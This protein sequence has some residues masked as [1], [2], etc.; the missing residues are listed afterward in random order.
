MFSKHKSPIGAGPMLSNRLSLKRIC[1]S[2]NWSV[3]TLSIFSNAIRTQMRVW[4]LRMFW[5]WNIWPSKLTKN[6]IIYIERLTTNNLSLNSMRWFVTFCLAVRQ[7]SQSLR[8]G[9]W[10]VWFSRIWVA[11]LNC[12]IF[13]W[14]PHSS[15]DTVIH[16][17]GYVWQCQWG[18]GGLKQSSIESHLY[19]K[20]VSQR[21]SL[22]EM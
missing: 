5:C 11:I 9:W 17:V 13:G 22:D 1:A 14:D 3:T 16:N 8:F 12:I 20:S 7:K 6:N 21:Y 10:I 19:C 2:D 4:P 18:G 15:I